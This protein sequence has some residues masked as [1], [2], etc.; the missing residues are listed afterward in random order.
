M[1][2]QKDGAGCALY[3]HGDRDKTP[4]R[5]LLTREAWITA[6]APFPTQERYH[7]AN[8]AAHNWDVTL[9]GERLLISSLWGGGHWVSRDG[10]MS[11]TSAAEYEALYP[12]VPKDLSTPEGKSAWFSAREV[13]QGRRRRQIDRDALAKLAN[14]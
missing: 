2:S 3:T 8:L 13:D 5:E 11:P 12:L 14:V 6:M 7:A 9:V 1:T 10:S 4:V